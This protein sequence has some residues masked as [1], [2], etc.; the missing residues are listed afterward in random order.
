MRIAKLDAFKKSAWNSGNSHGDSQF[1]KEIIKKLAQEN[2]IKLIT[3]ALLGKSP[4]ILQAKFEFD[5]EKKEVLKCPIGQMPYKTRYYETTGLFR[6]SF[7]KAT[8]LNSPFKDHCGIKV[9]KKSAVV[10]ISEKKYN[11]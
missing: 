6:V 8:C 5:M 7:N 3:T 11:G 9:Q 1:C 10:M 2:N 4:D